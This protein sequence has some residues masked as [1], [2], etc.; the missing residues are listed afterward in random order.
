MPSATPTSD[1]LRLETD[2]VRAQVDAVLSEPLYWF[3][4]RHHSPAVASHLQSAIEG[5]RPKLIFIE[6]PH[7]ANELIPHITLEPPPEAWPTPED[8]LDEDEDQHE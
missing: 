1:R 7:E 3:P 5:R 6:G 4:V 8:F 2:A